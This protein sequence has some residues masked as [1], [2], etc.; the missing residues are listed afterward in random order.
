MM[1]MKEHVAFY[2]ANE[3]GRKE[4]SLLQTRNLFP[5]MTILYVN[6]FKT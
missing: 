1:A 2:T 6:S 5:S 4:K 3:N